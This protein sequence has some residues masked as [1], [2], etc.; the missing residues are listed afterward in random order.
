MGRHSALAGGRGHSY[1]PPFQIKTPTVFMNVLGLDRYIENLL[2]IMTV[3]VTTVQSL[4][5]C[6]EIFGV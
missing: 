6:C 1:I 3:K 2:E 4:A 5:T